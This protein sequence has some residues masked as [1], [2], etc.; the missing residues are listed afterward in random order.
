MRSSSTHSSGKRRWVDSSASPQH[1]YSRHCGTC[2]KSKALGDVLQRIKRQ[3][4]PAHVRKCHLCWMPC[5][6]LTFQLCCRLQLRVWMG[7]SCSRS[8]S[9]SPGHSARGHC[10]ADGLLVTAAGG[11][12]VAATAGG[13][14]KMGA[15]VGSCRRVLR[16]QSARENADGL[17]LALLRLD[18]WLIFRHDGAV[19]IV[20]QSIESCFCQDI[21]CRFSSSRVYSAALSNDC[22][23]HLRLSAACL[24]SV[25]VG[26]S[27]SGGTADCGS[28]NAIA[29]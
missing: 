9:M 29:S 12:P 7:R 3:Q 13:L 14:G 18:E 22:I 5:Q 8:Q 2:C 23:I 1:S 21:N 28:P 24:M 15:A 10:A 4:A 25:C 17:R 6:Y 16:S 19:I 11:D 26:H 27:G 20:Q